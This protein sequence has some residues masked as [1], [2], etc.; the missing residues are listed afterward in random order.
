MFTFLRR[1]DSFILIVA[2]FISSSLFLSGCASN[3]VVEVADVEIVDSEVVKEEVVEEGAVKEAD[4]EIAASNVVEEE[5][6]EEDS[7]IDPFEGMNRKVYVFNKALDD[8]VAA[9]VSDAYLWVTPQFVQT[10]IANFISNLKD[11][12][13]VL[14]DLMQG[15]VDQGGQDTGRF[16]VNTTLGLAGLFDVATELGLEKHDEDFAQTLAVWGVPQGPYLVL[17]VIGPST[18]RGVPGGVFDY[19]ANPASYI[20]VP[21]QLVQML[22][23][24]ANATGAL[25]FIDEA[26]LDPYVFTRESFLQYRQ[27]LITDGEAEISNDTL[28]FEDDFYDEDEDDLAVGQEK[29]NSEVNKDLPEDSSQISKNNVE[30]NVETPDYKLDLSS[31]VDDF[32]DASNSFDGAVKSFDEASSSFEEAAEKLKRY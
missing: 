15:K 8:Y 18:G 31:D 17:P 24:R 28:D 29:G 32:G 26:A 7:V 6:V 20:G 3:E 23:A 13:V 21:I 19:A 11:I 4:G 14:N 25:K 1:K 12:N 27:H 10:G 5:V 2:F 22:N 16:V 30:N 9:P